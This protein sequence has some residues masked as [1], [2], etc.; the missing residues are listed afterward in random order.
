MT[1]TLADELLA[2]AADPA[3]YRRWAEQVVQV[4]Y[5]ERP[6]RLVGQVEQANAE[7]GEVCT[8]YASEDEPDGVT[9]KACG[10]RRASRCQPCSEIYRRD[11]WHLVAAGL[12]GGKGVPAGV[13]T[14]PRLFVTF[15]APS[16][17]PIHSRRER[18]GTVR[19][20]HPRNPTARCQHGR[21]TGCWRRHEA[22]DPCLGEPICLDCFDYEAAVMW[23]ALA[24]AL[25]R[26]TTI[27][28]RRALARAA[29]LTP[30]E[31][32]RVVQV[33]YAKVA[34]YQRRG[35]VHF[36]ALI[37]LDAAGSG[38]GEPVEPPP[39]EFTVEV[40]EHAVR[41]AAGRVAVRWPGVATA[42]QWGDQLDIRRIT[43]SEGPEDLCAEVVARWSRP[44]S[45]NTRPRARRRSARSTGASWAPTSSTWT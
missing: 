26:R 23:N 41:E 17:G 9:L 6:V 15:T 29:G 7:T 45:P 39:P 16:F 14:H 36:H 25:W 4:G 31:L 42:A 32:A 12:R 30:A 22:D 2:R 34:E 8:T 27:Y 1:A 10:N 38:A 19:P 13:A 28:L 20:C 5:C 37:R 21:P 18:G 33:S 43:A 11:A 24:P 44:T 35:V 40:L 3:A